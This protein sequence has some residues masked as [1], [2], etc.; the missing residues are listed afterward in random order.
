[1]YVFINET[2]NSYQDNLIYIVLF[3]TLLS[4]VV[5]VFVLN[6]WRIYFGLPDF[7]NW[8]CAYNIIVIADES[9][10]V[11]STMESQVQ[12]NRQEEGR[13]QPISATNYTPNA[14]PNYATASAVPAVEM[15][16]ATTYIDKSMYSDI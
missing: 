7:M 6:I 3:F 15:Q 12:N 13:P 10:S 14:P 16:T 2:N 1:M 11:V 9:N 5:C 4:I 8:W